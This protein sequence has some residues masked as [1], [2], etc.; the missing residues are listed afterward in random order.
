M[1]TAAVP[2]SAIEALGML[3]RGL[4]M[5]QSAASFLGAVGAADLPTE[6]LAEGLRALESADAVGAAVCS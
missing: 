2:A 6:T 3:H 1:C 5:L 4:D